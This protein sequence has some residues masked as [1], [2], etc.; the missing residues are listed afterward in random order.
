MQ[1]KDTI[2]AI[3]TPLG[4]GGIGVIRISGSSV[5]NVAKKILHILPNN[6]YA[7]YLP[8]FDE[9]NNILDY[10][11]AIYFKSPKSLTGEDILELHSHGNPII[12][13]TILNIIINIKNVRVANNGEF[14]ERAFLN[15][16]INL[17]QAES[18]AER[19]ESN[20]I[21]YIKSSIDNYFNE[22][23]SNYVKE[24]IKKVE[25]L[26]IYIESSIDFVE[27]EIYFSESK[28]FNTIKDIKF[29]IEDLLNKSKNNFSIRR[30]IKVVML[31][32]PNSGK[33]SIINA[34]INENAAIVTNVPGTTRDILS[35]FIYIDNF[36]FEIIDT[37]GI[38][39]NP[40]NKI[41]KIGINKTI[42]TVKKANMI[43]MVIDST[44]M[45][46]SEQI[47]WI[48]YIKEKINFDKKIL[49]VRNKSDISKENIGAFKSNN[50]NIINISA[51]NMLGIEILKKYI[52][53]EFCE[54]SN[55]N[56][57]VVRKRHISLLKKSHNSIKR[58]KTY[59]SRSFEMEFLAEEVR[60]IKNNLYEII[61]VNQNPDIIKKIFSKFCIGK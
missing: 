28:I 54:T 12:L 11:I 15:D 33:S 50:F 43:L 25:N 42:E 23:I 59:F 29:D 39:D 46:L 61:G 55:E 56:L 13:D 4:R 9:E 31:G 18:I 58:C 32:K 30:G 5:Q 1:F 38:R 22:N 47:L 40:I 20:S 53:K 49:V 48:D 44:Q 26:Q 19:I 6:R 10:G 3:A 27:E 7:T 45:S 51:K 37:A 57:F 52:K 14:L 8:F 36:L 35:K 60:Y 41:E 17:I 34:I 21:Q 24:I 2:A 16:K